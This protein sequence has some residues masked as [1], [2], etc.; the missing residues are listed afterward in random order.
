MAQQSGRIRGLNILHVDTEMEWRGGQAQLLALARALRERGHKQT[1]AACAKSALAKRARAEGIEVVTLHRFTG[2]RTLRR[3][4]RRFDLIHTHSARAQNLVWLATIG[5]SVKKV[6]SR[7]VAFEPRHPS[8]HRWKYTHTC[9]G[10]IA[11]SD[12]V[13]AVLMRCGA[14][15]A[16]IRVVEAGVEPPAHIP[17]AKERSAAR[18]QYGLGDSDF[19]IGHAG[20]FTPEKGQAVLLEAFRL[21]LDRMPR[22]WL[23]LAGSGPL[24]RSS[25]ILASAARAMGRAILLGQVEDIGEFLAALDVFVMPSLSEGWGL[26]ALEAMARGIPVVA[27]RTGGLERIVADGE[28]GWL[29]PPGDS[30]ALAA[31]LFNAGNDLQRL[32]SMGAAARLRAEMFSITAA[33]AKTEAFYKEIL[34]SPPPD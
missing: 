8:L 34:A 3:A 20:A 32:H 7:L 30:K 24:A 28:T 9:D 16:R 2:L 31:A 15:P 25:A 26:A 14:P 29:V 12:A 22:A 23:L 4:A 17:D 13:A 11:A 6:V 5:L 18:R 19:V 21:L 33:A 27:S 10:I 1:I